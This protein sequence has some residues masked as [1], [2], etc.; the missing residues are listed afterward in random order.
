MRRGG[1][2]IWNVKRDAERI[3]VAVGETEIVIGRE[4]VEVAPEVGR[5]HDQL[6]GEEV[7]GMQRS[8]NY[9][10]RCGRYSNNA[11]NFP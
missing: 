3:G 7:T 4:E 9:L 1:G 6:A 10:L 5:V 8:D 2:R 11:S